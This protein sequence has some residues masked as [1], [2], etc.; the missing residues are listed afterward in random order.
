VHRNSRSTSRTYS[1][2]SSQSSYT[3]SS[4]SKSY[5]SSSLSSI[6]SN[7]LDKNDKDYRF[8]TKEKQT[9]GDIDE[10]F[11]QDIPNDDDMLIVNCPIQD[12]ELLKENEQ[13]ISDREKRTHSKSVKSKK[14]ERKKSP[15]I[16]RP[17]SVTV[18]LNSDDFD[19][20]Q[21]IKKRRTDEPSGNNH[22]VVQILPKTVH[23]TVHDRLSSERSDKKYHKH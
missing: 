17:V 8:E 11:P 9:T 19:L 10:R 2:S 13:K 12:D 6:S 4:I 7:S 5:S 1:S 14:E 21:L 18:K 20:R 16:E 3:H 22:R 15:P 23:K